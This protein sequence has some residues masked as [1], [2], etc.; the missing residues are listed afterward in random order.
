MGSSRYFKLWVWDAGA[1]QWREISKLNGFRFSIGMNVVAEFS[2]TAYVTT[3]V[4]QDLMRADTIFRITTDVSTNGYCQYWHNGTATGEA[5]TADSYEVMTGRLADP[6]YDEKTQRNNRPVIYHL[7]GFDFM[8][9]VARLTY[10]NDTTLS[11]SANAV[12]ASIAATVGA[13]KVVFDSANS[14]AGPTIDLKARKDNV[15]G[16]FMDIAKVGD[17]TFMAY[18]D[19]THNSSFVPVVTYRQYNHSTYEVADPFSPRDNG[20]ILDDKTEVRDF[21]LH[22][23]RDRVINRVIVRYAGFGTGIAMAETAA[24]TSV[25]FGES[26]ERIARAPLIQSSATAVTFRDTILAMYAGTSEGLIRT[27]AVLKTAQLFST[28]FDAVLGDQVGI[29]RTGTEITQGKFL[30]AEYNQMNEEIRVTIGL[31]RS[32]FYDTFA[33]LERMVQQAMTGMKTSVTNAAGLYDPSNPTYQVALSAAQVIASGGAGGW[34]GTGLPTDFG[35]CELLFMQLTLDVTTEAQPTVDSHTHSYDKATSVGS[36][37]S[38]TLGSD[39]HTHTITTTPTNSGSS[40]PGIDV[41]GP[42]QVVIT[43][44]S[45]SIDIV[46]AVFD[47]WPR[48]KQGKIITKTY[49]FPFAVPRG[50]GYTPD[51]VVVSIENFGDKSITLGTNSKL[52]M[53]KKPLHNHE[54]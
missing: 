29:E 51:N 50:G 38:G 36:G 45:G 3:T 40:A 43:L 18:I 53:W 48:L 2:S 12:M 1:V 28:S 7:Q 46:N 16:M 19:V 39:P 6:T 20:R 14:S 34:S 22:K 23:E 11:G 26:R 37:N 32:H 42:Y 15:M 10:D 30:A 21:K 8:E 24:V 4:V 13:S 9:S 44:N 47:I 31:P 33:N 5:A 52:T 35:L 49:I 25:T 54:M 17:G 41:V 27:E